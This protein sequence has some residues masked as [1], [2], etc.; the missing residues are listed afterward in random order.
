M[1][2]N[3]QTDA[4]ESGAALDWR[5]VGGAEVPVSRRFDDPYF[6]LAGGLAETRHVF[7]AGNGL[8]ARLVPGFHVAETGFGTGLNLLALAQVAP[9]ANAVNLAVFIGTTLRGGP[10]ALA[11]L[12]GLIGV[13]A[14]LVL[15]AGAL[16]LRQGANPVVD[17]A[18]A[19]LG[20]AAVG[21]ILAN[22]V[23]ITRDSLRGMRQLGIVAV[24]SVGVGV[25]GWPL[26]PTLLVAIPASIALMALGAGRP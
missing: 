16:L 18:L 7:L 20:A 12:A 5:A 25:L 17:A 2:G 1:S 8:P 4:M 3:D 6:S 22:G 24:L 13:P 11:S 15:A 23:Q 14:A 9:G 21:L 10:G 26:V 19:G